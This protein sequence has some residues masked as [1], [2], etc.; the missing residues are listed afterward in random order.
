[1]PK[2]F[3]RHNSTYALVMRLYFSAASQHAMLHGETPCRCKFDFY[4]IQVDL[5]RHSSFEDTMFI[6]ALSKLK[7]FCMQVYNLC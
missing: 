7:N 2:H 4:F 6:M 1:M 5:M 3:G